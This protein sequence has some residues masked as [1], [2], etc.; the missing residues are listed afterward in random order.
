MET[1]SL[2][3][4]AWC[5]DVIGVGGRVRAAVEGKAGEGRPSGGVRAGGRERVAWAKGLGA[6][7]WVRSFA[8]SD[9]TSRR[10]R[11]Q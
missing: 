4:E 3:A 1:A 2:I 8:V 10:T 6:R 9:T 5:S 11:R 7:E